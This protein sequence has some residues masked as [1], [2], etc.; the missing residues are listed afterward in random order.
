MNEKVFER[1]L[2]ES[3]LARIQ[4]TMGKYDCGTITAF[5]D[6]AFYRNELDKI[7]KSGYNSSN[8][9]VVNVLQSWLEET[10]ASFKEAQDTLRG[11]SG[12]NI[13]RQFNIDRNKALVKELMEKGY[14]VTAIDGVGQE[15]EYIGKKK[16]KKIHEVQENS[17]FVA[18]RFGK[19][20]LR[21]DLIALGKKYQQ[22]GVTYIPA[23]ESDGELIS[24]ED[25]S[26]ADT[27]SNRGYG[28]THGSPFYSKK[29]NRSFVF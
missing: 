29:S 6:V 1:V 18:D 22:W 28:T 12:S 5:K 19:G 3:G 26:V 21:N 13:V 23:G 8:E 14:S 20:N 10:G 2:R 24:C 15:E 11:P 27:L 7:R 4:S 25:G 17:Y 16:T 9:T